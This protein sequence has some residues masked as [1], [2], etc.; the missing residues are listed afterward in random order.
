MFK[1]T[2]IDILRPSTGRSEYAPAILTAAGP[3]PKYGW[4]IDPEARVPCREPSPRRAKGEC[5]MDLQQSITVEQARYVHRNLP[6][7]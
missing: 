6:M 5:T 3:I 7:R 1:R 2:R 4:V